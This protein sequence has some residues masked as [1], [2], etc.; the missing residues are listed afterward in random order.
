MNIWKQDTRSPESYLQVCKVGGGETDV[1]GNLCLV[2]SVVICTPVWIWRCIFFRLRPATSVMAYIF[3]IY[4]TC[5]INVCSHMLY[6]RYDLEYET[7]RWCLVK[8][9]KYGTLSMYLLKV[10][11]Y[12]EQLKV[13]TSCDSVYIYSMLKCPAWIPNPVSQVCFHH[14]NSPLLESLLFSF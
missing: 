4:W 10:I 13:T 12:A 6:T 14:L 11:N 8:Y 1:L 9:E 7:V 5:S 2:W 3:T